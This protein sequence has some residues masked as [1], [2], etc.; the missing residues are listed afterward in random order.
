MLTWDTSGNSESFSS[1]SNPNG[2]LTRLFWAR[3]QRREKSGC[4]NIIHHTLNLHLCFHF[5]L[6]TGSRLAL[7]KSYPVIFLLIHHLQFYLH[8]TFNI[9]H[10]NKR[11]YRNPG[12]MN[13]ELGLV[14]WFRQLF[15]YKRIILFNRLLFSKEMCQPVVI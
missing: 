15:R 13:N 1:N 9:L 7:P 8:D 12:G 2:I 10:Q 14:A 6:F 11:V 4:Q 5:T 3:F